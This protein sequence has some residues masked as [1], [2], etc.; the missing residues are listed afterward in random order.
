MLQVILGHGYIITAEITSEIFHA[1]HAPEARKVRIFKDD[2][3]IIM[4]LLH[5][6]RS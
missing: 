6:A 3:Y 1:I 4:I 5:A 2:A